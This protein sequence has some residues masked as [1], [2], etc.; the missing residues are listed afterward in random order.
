MKGLDR[1]D[2]L[3]ERKFTGVESQRKTVEA[4]R[5]QLCEST[6]FYQDVSQEELETVIRATREE[7]STWTPTGH[8]YYCGNGHPVSVPSQP[9]N[10]ANSS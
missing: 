4:A 10:H 3:C 8:W 2:K 1:A 9:P 5:K 7:L 6:T